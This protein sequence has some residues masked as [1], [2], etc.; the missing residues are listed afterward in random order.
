MSKERQEGEANRIEEGVPVREIQQQPAAAPAPNN[1]QHEDGA[2]IGTL[3]SRYVQL[4]KCEGPPV[5][6]FLRYQLPPN[7]K[8]M[9]DKML[10]L[11][12][13]SNRHPNTLM[14]ILAVKRRN[15]HVYIDTEVADALSLARNI[16]FV[17][18]EYRTI[19]AKSVVR[20]VLSGLSYYA[21]V[22]GLPHRNI[23]PA[24]IFLRRD[25]NVKCGV[26][27]L[28]NQKLIEN[29]PDWFLRSPFCA[30]ESKISIDARLNSGSAQD[31]WSVGAL[32]VA[33]MLG[34]TLQ[35]RIKP[36]LF[37]GDPVMTPTQEQRD[38]YENEIRGFEEYLNGSDEVKQRIIPDS[39][40]REIANWCL[41]LNPQDRPT[42]DDAFGLIRAHGS[43]ENAPMLLKGEAMAEPLPARLLPDPFSSNSANMANANTHR[44]ILRDALSAD[45]AMPLAGSTEELKLW[46]LARE[47]DNGNMKKPVDRSM[48]TAI[49]LEQ[50]CAWTALQHVILAT[51]PYIRPDPMARR[52]ENLRAARRGDE[53]EKFA[54]GI[55]IHD[56]NRDR[57]TANAVEKLIS[58]MDN[59]NEQRAPDFDTAIAHDLL[60][61]IRNWP[62]EKN[63]KNIGLSAMRALVK[64]P[65]NV[66][67][68]LTEGNDCRSIY[69]VNGFTL[70]N[71]IW[72]FIKTLPPNDRENA[73]IGLVRSL[74]E[75][76]DVCIWGK[77]QRI[78]LRVVSGNL[79]DPQGKPISLGIEAQELVENKLTPTQVL[80]MFFMVE[81]NRGQEEID[82]HGNVIKEAHSIPWLK[83]QFELWVA[84]QIGI[85][86]ALKLQVLQAIEEYGK[87][88][89]RRVEATAYFRY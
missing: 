85:D 55:G 24:S 29:N 8:W 6:I 43:I 21:T 52:R 69:R 63:G 59:K 22:Q 45:D 1:Q 84:D 78:M 23:C 10:H 42:F 67:P 46:K 16:P 18:Q 15:G 39:G 76:A 19:V 5:E 79:K 32:I 13:Q 54:K 66:W 81:A 40:L 65:E 82:I 74:A 37:P 49:K 89:D 75:G 12:K 14:F 34:K 3:N 11:A 64:S 71:V 9:A 38:E 86:A 7:L 30:P 68:A 36:A 77:I 48:R 56:A 28:I 80:N 44:Q 83:R 57:A 31:V 47:K 58:F 72:D 73:T 53:L 26:F 17:P 62:T 60:E 25:G 50:S 2:L 61:T 70:I 35:P 87:V 33:I 27:D 51:E 41:K 88:D 20:Q 4:M